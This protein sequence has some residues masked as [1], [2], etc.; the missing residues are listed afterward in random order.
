MSAVVTTGHG[1]VVSLDSLTVQCSAS[2]AE[3]DDS[4]GRF[5]NEGGRVGPAV[6]VASTGPV[7]GFRTEMLR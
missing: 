1:C 3:L 4:L 2:C 5:E 6:A 7:R